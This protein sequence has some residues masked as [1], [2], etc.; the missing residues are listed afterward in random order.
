MREGFEI[1]HLGVRCIAP[2]PLDDPW[3]EGLVFANIDEVV[4]AYQRGDVGIHATI[5]VRLDTEE[6]LVEGTVGRVLLYEALPAGAP[7]DWCNRAMK[8]RDLT[9]LVSRVYREYGKEAT[10]EFLDKIKKLIKSTS[11]I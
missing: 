10:V 1:E 2:S 3:G 11:A 8:S 4:A 7:F 5:K 6:N 9:K